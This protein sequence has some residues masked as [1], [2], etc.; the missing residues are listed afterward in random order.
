M[1]YCASAVSA[2][3]C[4]SLLLGWDFTLWSGGVNL[5]EVS[6][7]P[8]NNGP[9]FFSFTTENHYLIFYLSFNFY[10]SITPSIAV[11]PVSCFLAYLTI[12]L[13]SFSPM[14]I[15]LFSPPSFH[16]LPVQVNLCESLSLIC[17]HL[18]QKRN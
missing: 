1:L 6:S 14:I 9:F 5:K 4:V 16:H 8:N 18:R 10:F 11:A 13:V 12:I 15:L 2:V 17:C 3:D 7:V